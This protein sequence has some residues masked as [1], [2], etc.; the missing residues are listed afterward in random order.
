[1]PL[2]INTFHPR[3]FFFRNRSGYGSNFRRPGDRGFWSLALFTRVP[4]WAPILDPQPHDTLRFPKCGPNS[5]KVPKVQPS[6]S[7]CC[8][9]GQAR[10]TSWFFGFHM[11]RAVF[12]HSPL[13][14][15]SPWDRR[16]RPAR[17]FRCCR[18]FTKEIF[19]IQA[20]RPQHLPNLPVGMGFHLFLFFF[21]V[22]IF[23]WL[24]F[25]LPPFFP[26]IEPI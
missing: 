15:S 19:C 5:V 16:R 1:M 22:S 23:F 11:S 10:V 7:R 21:L 20:S 26:V 2:P 12:D 6:I 8:F 25:F 4:F 17:T 3:T 14:M 24:L 13:S 9:F 18:R